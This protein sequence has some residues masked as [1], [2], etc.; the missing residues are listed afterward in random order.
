MTENDKN[1]IAY[2]FELLSDA[3]R[4]NTEEGQDALRI[5]IDARITRIL[6][7]EPD[8]DEILVDNPVDEALTG[9]DYQ[10]LEAQRLNDHLD[11]SELVKKRS[12]YRKSTAKYSEKN[13]RV[14]IGGK[15]VW[16][17]RSECKQ[18]KRFPDNPES[19]LFKW[20]WNG[21]AEQVDKLGDELWASHEAGEN[22]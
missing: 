22:N 16:K 17:P 6:N 15:P 4:R 8:D 20:I 11:N 19:N 5:E 3:S 9:S 12:Q 2:L 10:A 18:V 21:P 13:V 7:D 14:Y 1:E